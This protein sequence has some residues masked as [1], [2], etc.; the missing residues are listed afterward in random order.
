[1]WDRM[2]F[3]PIVLHISRIRVN[4]F[5]FMKDYETA[6]LDTIDKRFDLNANFIFMD[7]CI[8]R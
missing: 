7:T 5:S 6:A 3:G 8:Y 1:M 4:F 2:P